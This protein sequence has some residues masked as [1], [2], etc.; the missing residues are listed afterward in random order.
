[1]DARVLLIGLD[2]GWPSD[3]YRT[4]IWMGRSRGWDQSKP[5]TIHDAVADVVQRDPAACDK[6]SNIAITRSRFGLD[7]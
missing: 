2:L 5:F 4:G 6:Y 1:M 3:L 7:T